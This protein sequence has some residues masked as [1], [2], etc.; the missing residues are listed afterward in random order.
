MASSTLITPISPAILSSLAFALTPDADRGDAASATTL[1]TIEQPAA[2]HNGGQIAFGPDGFLYIGMGD[3][4]GAGDVRGN[5]QN[6]AVLLG[7]MLRIDVDGAEPYGIPSDN[8][9][10][11][12]EGARPEIW[13]TGL[14]NPW[15]FSFDRMTGD[16]FIG[17]VGQNRLEEIN[18][19]PAGSK[20]A[21][22]MAGNHGRSRLLPAFQRLRAGWHGCNR[23][24]IIHMTRVAL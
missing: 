17:D 18:I 9:F 13:A 19:E 20:V 7:K 6:P 12:T 3:G 5:A 1:L 11:R 8:P 21:L 16:M 23:L 14:R 24:W 10:V 15:R 4:G 22:T 2:N